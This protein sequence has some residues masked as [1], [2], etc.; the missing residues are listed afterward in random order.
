MSYKIYLNFT[1]RSFRIKVL[2]FAMMK[3]LAQPLKMCKNV[4][5][6][7]QEVQALASAQGALVIEYYNFVVSRIAKQCKWKSNL[8]KP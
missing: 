5:T 8:Y 6:E 4:T 3:L 1:I 2:F 7:T